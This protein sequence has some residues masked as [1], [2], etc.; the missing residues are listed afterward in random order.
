MKTFKEFKSEQQHISELGPIGTAIAGAMGLVGLGIAGY[1]LFNKAKEGIKGYRE[2][3]ADKKARKEDG[4]TMSVKVYNPET[5]REESQDFYI[6][7]IT[8]NKDLEKITGGKFPERTSTRRIKAPSDDELD[9]MEKDANRKSKRHNL[10]IK[11]KIANDEITD[12]DLTSDQ[13]AQLATKRAE[14]EKPPEDSSDSGQDSSETETDD[15]DERPRDKEGN[16]TDKKDAQDEFE[17]SDF[18]K[19]PDGWTKDPDNEKEVITKAQAEKKKKEKKLDPKTKASADKAK[20]RMRKAGIRAVAAG[21]L[22]KFGEFIS[23]GI[24]NDLKKASKSRKDSEITLDDGADIPIDPL[25]SQI[26]VKYIEGL[27]SSEKNKTIKQIQ[28]T[29]RAFLKVLGKAHEG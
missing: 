19:A 3:K 18:K 25:T 13:Q 28:R 1:K 10:K 22:L 14:K 20:K 16:L 11:R 27:S 12:D 2:T 21:R 9:K 23:E 29:E 6:D 8:G 15:E 4:F 5:E 17:K 24:M 26:L 7:P